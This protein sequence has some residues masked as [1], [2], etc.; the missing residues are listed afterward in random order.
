MDNEQEALV[1][2]L[3][4]ARGP[5]FGTP[6]STPAPDLAPDKALGRIKPVATKKAPPPEKDRSAYPGDPI[7]STL[8][9]AFDKFGG[10]DSE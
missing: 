2:E 8:A 4:K 7:K 1:K 9:K 10:I 6:V 3:R 5:F